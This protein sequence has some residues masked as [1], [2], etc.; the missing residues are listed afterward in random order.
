[1]VGPGLPRSAGNL[2]P[3]LT[4]FVGREADL[5][6]VARLIST[7]RLVTL[8]GPGGIGK[9]RVALRAAHQVAEAFP[10]GVWL[11]D[12]APVSDPGLIVPHLAESL[13][14][15]DR[16]G[17]DLGDALAGHLAERRLLLV[18]D[19][20]DQLPDACAELVERLLRRSPGLRVLATGRRPLHAIGEHV[21]ALRALPVPPADAATQPGH[22]APAFTG[23]AVQLFT[24]QAEA[25]SGFAVTDDNRGAVIRLC[26]RLEGNPLAVELAAGLLRGVT[27]EQLLDRLDDRLDLLVRG[28]GA[29]RHRALR[30]S[31]GW[32]HEMCA[33]QERLLWARLSVFGGDFDLAAAEAV[34]AD[35]D[36]PKATIIAVL[37]GLVDKSVVLRDET[38]GDVRYVLPAGVRQYGQE[39]LDRLGEEARLRRAHA[40][41]FLDLVKTAERV[42]LGP[43][44]DSWCRWLRTERANV[45]AALEL[46]I[47][48][49]G[50][51]QLALAMCTGL[52]TYWVACGDLA[53]GRYW[54]ERALDRA[55]GSTPLR[56]RALWMTSWLATLQGDHAAA[57]PLLRECAEL[58]TELGY[59]AALASALQQTAGI[60]M[61]Q[62]DYDSAL[63]LFEEALIQQ[64]ALGDRAAVM[65]LLVHL[66]LCYVLRGDVDR[67]DLDRAIAL[68]EESLRRSVSHGE[69]WFRS[70]ALHILALASWRGGDITSAEGLARES[71]AV[72]R[73]LDDRLSIGMSLELL[74]WIAA[75]DERCGRAARLAGAA[76]AIW[77]TTGAPLSGVEQ[78]IGYHEGALGHVRDVLGPTAY[79]EAFEK[80]RRAPLERTLEDVVP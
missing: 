26:R 38:S 52:W 17:R 22:T 70:Q 28:D 13:G 30:T 60:A 16:S 9:T 41:H 64:R 39:W 37:A 42:W 61:F 73:S 23:T 11:A 36:L 29:D 65:T 55:T 47:S 53:E 18:M 59:E 14:V 35:D 6:D 25:L 46:R 54:F 24:E 58:A 79:E 19:T 77:R 31:I 78:L 68:C 71:L 76:E 4:G 56:A 75:G 72:S 48:E 20:C 67:G 69:T 63:R 74:A 3:E 1:M 10:D 51:G 7:A 49:P 15:R 34:C 2:P 32:S 80:G 40:D 66:A 57:G 27:V 33:P 5:R 8:T 44:Q 50:A 12:L 62:G 21:V 45:R 43:D